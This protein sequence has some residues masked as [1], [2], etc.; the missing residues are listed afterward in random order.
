MKRISLSKFGQI[1]QSVME[2]L[3]P[4]IVQHL[5]NVVVDVEEEPDRKMLLEM[6]F[7][8]E[9]IEAGDSLYGLFVPMQLAMPDNVDFLDHPHRILIFKNPLEES[10]PDR[11]PT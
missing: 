10:F 4:E 5:D 11:A 8:P 1:V 2:T 9:E 6:G 3:P 7:T